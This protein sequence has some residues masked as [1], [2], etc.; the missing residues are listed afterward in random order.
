MSDSKLPSVAW[1]RAALATAPGRCKLDLILGSADPAAFVRRLPAEDLYFAVR[2]IGLADAADVVALAAPGQFRAFVDLDA[3][4]HDRPDPARVLQWLRLAGEGGGPA[5]LR[6][7]RKALDAEILLLTLRAHVVVHALEE[8][9]EPV[10]EHDDF[11]RTPEGKYVVE[12]AAKGDEGRTLR[13]VLE[14]LVDEN[15]FESARLFEALRW[16]LSS[17]LEEMS[18]RW[19]TGRMRDMGFPDPEEAA[20]V[21]TPLPDGAAGLRAPPAEPGPLSGV[22]ALLLV[23]GSAIL[24]LDRAAE[25]LEDDARTRF[26][27][28]L[29]YLLNCA[30][31]AEGVE[32]RDLDHARPVLVAARDMLSLGLEIASNGDEDAAAGTLAATPP[33]LLF[34]L[35]VARLFSVARDAARAARRLGE[36]APAANLL[37]SPDAEMIAGLLRRH[38]RIHDPRA[39]EPWRAPRDRAD[40]DAA[41]RTVARAVA[42]AE[43]LHSMRIDRT[44]LEGIAERAG[45]ARTAVTVGQLVLTAAVR[46]AL[47]VPE[48]APVDAEAAGRLC[49]LFDAGRLSERARSSIERFFAGLRASLPPDVRPALDESIPG[50]ISRLE[51]EPG[52][53][54]AAGGFDPTLLECVLAE[55]AVTGIGA[56]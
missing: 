45:R 52:P 31:V 50:W 21:W 6:R 55:A 39:A 23:G 34:R 25:R 27:E 24:L 30:L 40:L 10:L 13:R 47:D 38:P 17:E 29:V 43:V 2:E 26:N 11:I 56:P 53:A 32:P 15:P 35:A 51:D 36:V 12:I 46:A 54:C 41:S 22:P 28:G 44:A 19:R 1:S 3:W 49:S 48:T 16:E 4:Q 5:D 33:K 8:E 9:P 18:L 7:K 14:D 20:V 42:S 37:D